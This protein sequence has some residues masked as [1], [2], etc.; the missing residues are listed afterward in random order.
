MMTFF[1]TRSEGLLI[2]PTHRVVSNLAAF[3]A[4]TLLQERGRRVRRPGL[5]FRQRLG[6]LG[7]LRAISPQVWP[8]HAR[9][10]HAIGMY[11]AAFS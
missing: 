8:R 11:G 6:A 4:D 2:L 3:D 10:G 1:N 9:E 5:L 7:G